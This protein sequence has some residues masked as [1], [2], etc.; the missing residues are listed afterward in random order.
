MNHE[1]LRT[2][3]REKRAMC[4]TPF[5]M[6]HWLDFYDLPFSEKKISSNILQK[7]HELTHTVGTIK[8]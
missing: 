6:S 8:D 1:G 7:H 5:D 4:Y 3:I 2:T